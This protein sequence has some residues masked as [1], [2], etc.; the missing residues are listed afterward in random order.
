MKSGI[1]GQYPVVVAA[2]LLAGF[3]SA[4]REAGLP[5]IPGRA[6]N[7]L[8]A[9]RI[10][11]LREIADLARAG[12]VTLTASPDEFPIFDAVFDNWFG[13]RIAVAAA[14]SDDEDRRRATIAAQRCGHARCPG[15]RRRRH[16][17]LAGRFR[18]R[19]TFRRL[20]SMRM[21]HSGRLRRRLDHLPTIARRTWV[22]SPSGRRIDMARTARAARRTFRR[23]AAILRQTRPERPRKLLLLIDVSGS[24]KAQSEIYLSFAHLLAR[25]RPGVETFCFGTRLSR[26]SKT[27][28]RRNRDDALAKLSIWSST[29]MV[30]RSSARRSKASSRPRAMR[31]WCAARSSWSFRDGL[32][33]GDPSAMI[34]SVHRLGA[35][36]H[37]LV[38]I[39]PLA[40]D[41]R[42][43]PVTR[44]MAGILP[45]LDRIVDG[46]SL[47]SLERL[48]ALLE[49]AER[50]HAARRAGNF[51]VTCR[52][53]A[54]I[55]IVDAHH[56]IWRQTDLPWLQ[57]P[58]VP[59]IFGPYEPIRR[60]YPIEEF[61]ADIAGSGVEKSV[62]VQANWAKAQAVDEVAWVQSVAEQHGFPNAIVGY[63]DLLDENAAETLK[64]QS[65]FP[66]MRGIRMQL[67]WHEN[68]MYR[69]ARTARSDERSV[70]PQKPP[71]GGRPWLVVRP[72][73]FH[74]AN[75]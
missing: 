51:R 24:M 29:S 34:A 38:W 61:L 35:S 46:A 58:M 10:C 68:E 6:A 39:T 31:R 1:C 50:G 37:R 4:L 20:L 15:G 48:P 69:F 49:R 71:A 75:G 16:G 18:N 3:P 66:L 21:T 43:R 67:H 56:R 30:A 55:G 57:G 32:E 19:K 23:D 65:K 54:M 14:R 74:V 8:R 33:R 2:D 7:F 22:A 64:R 26:V 53:E 59:R 13:A 40:A 63:A 47:A 12:R 72:A 42:Y 60:D 11:R 27:L 45:A 5:M 28:K 62:Y 70:V 36:G 25:A 41:P 17:G 52:R 9:A 44:A 73:G